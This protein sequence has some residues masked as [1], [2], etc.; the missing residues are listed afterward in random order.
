MRTVADPA[1]ITHEWK[2][3]SPIALPDM[4]G[5]A[6]CHSF[7]VSVAVPIAETADAADACVTCF[8][9]VAGEKP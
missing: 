1:G 8:V 4:P 9:C 6:A 3:H 2:P 7:D 5:T